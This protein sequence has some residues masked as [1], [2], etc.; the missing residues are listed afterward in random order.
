[1]RW[2]WC[3]KMTIFADLQYYLCWRRWVGLKKPK[4]C[5]RN[6]WMVPNVQLCKTY[7]SKIHFWH[8]FREKVNK[9][10]PWTAMCV[11]VVH[12]FCVSFTTNKCHRKTCWRVQKMLFSCE[13]LN[14]F[15]QKLT[16][17]FE[18]EFGHF[19][20]SKKSLIDSRSNYS[21]AI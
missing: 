10:K 3:Q 21:S 20:A 14:C 4:T 1:M 12:H 11:V 15:L 16:N 17:Y 19:F 18:S 8:I 2:R 13:N 9:L 5:W 7:I 6:T